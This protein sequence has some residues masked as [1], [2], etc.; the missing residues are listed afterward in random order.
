MHGGAVAR[1]PWLR[2]L[3]QGSGQA[4]FPL[5]PTS[6]S[7]LQDWLPPAPCPHA[8]L[9]SLTLCL[10]HSHAYPLSLSLSAYPLSLSRG[11]HLCEQQPQELMHDS[12][13]ALGP[14]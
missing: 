11:G 4:S 10:P 14:E 7:P 3:R 13:E 1:D 5:E 6:I 9:E 2:D 8:L 12:S